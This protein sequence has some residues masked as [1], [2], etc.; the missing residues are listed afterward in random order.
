MNIVFVRYCFGIIILAAHFLSIAIY[1]YLGVRLF[2]GIDET[3]GVILSIT[4][5]TSLYFTAFLRYVVGDAGD[6]IDWTVPKRSFYVQLSVIL[7]FCAFLLP[8]GATLFVSGRINYQS[9][10]V[11]TGLIETLF[12]AY[13]A[14]I[15]N[16]LFPE[17]MTGPTTP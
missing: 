1:G 16:S 17:T 5:L 14:I 6:V 12:A 8:V 15:F 11:Y 4:P 13:M 2:D 3:I 7:I 9:I 10:G